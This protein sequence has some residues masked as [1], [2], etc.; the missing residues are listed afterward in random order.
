[1]MMEWMENMEDITV[2]TYHEENPNGTAGRAFYKKMG[3]CYGSLTEEFGSSG[4]QFVPKK[5]FQYAFIHNCIF[6]FPLL[7][8][9]KI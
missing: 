5:Q 4:Q 7:L 3:F 6:S 8:N 9:I 2:I 1:M